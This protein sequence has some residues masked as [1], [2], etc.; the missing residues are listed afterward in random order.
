MDAFCK[1]MQLPELFRVAGDELIVLVYIGS[2]ENDRLSP[3]Q[4][5][6]KI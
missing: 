2:F 3:K 1:Q 5:K 6:C 4:N